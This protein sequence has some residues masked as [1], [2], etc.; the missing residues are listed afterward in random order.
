MKM[1]YWLLLIAPLFSCSK[2]NDPV[3][4]V[5]I[6]SD[7]SVFDVKQERDSISTV[8]IRFYIN[9][10]R[11]S[12]KEIKVDYST[13]TGG[14]AVA[15]SDYIATNGVITIPVGQ[16]LAFFNVSLPGKN[17]YEPDL[18]FF[19]QLS[20]AVNATIVG[21]GKAIG[22]ITSSKSLQTIDPSGYSTPLSYPGYTLAWSDEFAST[23]NPAFWTHEVGASGWGNN[24]LQNYTNTSANSYISGGALVIEARKE[25]NGQY[26][27]ARM[28]TAG[29][30]AFKHGRIDIRAKLPKGQGIWP[31]LWMLGSDIG[32]VGW[33]A[34]GEIDIMEVVGHEPAKLHGTA[35]WG[36]Q[37][38]GSS[39]NATATKT[40][41]TGDFSDKFHVFSIIWE[42]NKI[43]WYLDDVL[44]HTVT[45]A[46][47]GAANYPFNNEFFFILNVAVGGNWPGNPNAS[48]VFPQ[49]M[50]VDYVRV[51]Q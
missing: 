39:I 20:N 16:T 41:A 38:S 28:V 8:E 10:S 7:L 4:P 25:T 46:N 3:D 48:T 36:A 43:R 40:L 14:T 49:K 31:A 45:P 12:D 32:S 15:G 6:T 1:F 18:S 17:I 19:I 30:K 29:K 33:P 42:A 13:V 21:T 44:F 5:V 26:T 35:H 34:C 22:T 50:F 11:A 27:S 9:V 51:F 47:T 2:N 24:E 23:I 37:G